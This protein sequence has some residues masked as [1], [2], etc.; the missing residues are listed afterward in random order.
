MDVRRALFSWTHGVGSGKVSDVIVRQIE[1][2]KALHL[3]H[4]HGKALD[5]D[6]GV[7]G[8]EHVF[9]R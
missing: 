7:E 5:N 6:I 2:P 4:G 8:L 1:G 9:R 3:R